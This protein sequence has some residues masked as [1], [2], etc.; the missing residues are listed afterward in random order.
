MDTR[1]TWYKEAQGAASCHKF[2][3][4]LHDRD[5]Q[6]KLWLSWWLAIRVLAECSA[7]RALAYDRSCGHIPALFGTGS[8]LQDI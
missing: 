6:I 7:V 5:P 2:L 1:Y 8:Y 3:D 4:S